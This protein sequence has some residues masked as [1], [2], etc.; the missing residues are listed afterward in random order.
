LARLWELEGAGASAKAQAEDEKRLLA[1]A[2]FVMSETGDHGCCDIVAVAVKNEEE[3]R[4]EALIKTASW[5]CA[6]AGQVRLEEQTDTDDGELKGRKGDE[7]V[8]GP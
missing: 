1:S 5:E 3:W 4:N 7:E 2:C 6:L 8:S